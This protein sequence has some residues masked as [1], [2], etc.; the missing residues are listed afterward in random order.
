MSSIPWEVVRG[1]H[2][3][4]SAI[5]FTNLQNKQNMFENE[6]FK[7]PSAQLKIISVDTHDRLAYIDN[8]F[9]AKLKYANSRYLMPYEPDGNVLRL[10]LKY[11]HLGRTIK[12]YSFWCNSNITSQV[13]CKGAPRLCKGPDDGIKGGRIVTRLNAGND[14]DYFLVANPEEVN[15]GVIDGQPFSL[16]FEFMPESLEQDNGLDSTLWA[17]TDDPNGDYGSAI[18]ITPDGKLVFGIRDNTVDFDFTSPANKITEGLYHTAFVTY[19]PANNAITMRI[20]NVP[21][22]DIGGPTP[23]FP[24]PLNN[25]VWLGISGTDDITGGGGKFIGR[26]A[27]TRWYRGLIVNNNHHDNIWNNK[28]SICARQAAAFDGTDGILNC[29][30]HSNLWSQSLTKFSFAFWARPYSLSD[31]NFRDLLNHGNYANNGFS[32]FQDNSSDQWV[33]DITNN[34]GSEQTAIANLTRDILQWYFVV[35]TY[36]STLGSNQMKMYLDA[37]LEAQTNQTGAINKSAD[38]VLGGDSGIFNGEI[39][40]FKWWTTIALTQ[41]DINNLRAGYYELVTAPNYWI[42][43]AEGYDNPVDMIDRTKNASFSVN[44]G[45]KLT[46]SF[47]PIEYGKLDVMG[48]SR[49]NSQTYTAGYDNVGFDNV[50]YST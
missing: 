7:P 22:S 3:D 8:L 39:S 19:N 35:G 29:G 28:R 24:D 50:G 48:Y 49:F 12:D 32:V 38:L 46:S 43:I 18:T 37:R 30:N 10:W 21:Q 31:T 4:P 36:D 26:F 13:L 1:A 17:Q 25:S 5:K 2:I 34:S 42:K 16:Y 33:F 27:D 6:L 14:T 41:S 40:D 11:N 47:R 44:A 20:N 23:T 45:W 9:F 15:I